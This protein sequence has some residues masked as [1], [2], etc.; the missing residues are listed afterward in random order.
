MTT[1]DMIHIMKE[2]MNISPFEM[3][4]GVDSLVNTC[5]SVFGVTSVLILAEAERKIQNKS[6]CIFCSVI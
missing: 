3:I 1:R 6:L 5:H 4:V 2:L